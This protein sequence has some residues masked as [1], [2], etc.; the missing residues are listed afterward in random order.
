MDRLLA[1][2]NIALSNT[3]ALYFKI[4]SY[5]WNIEGSSFPQYHDFLNDAYQEIYESVDTYAEFIRALGAY[6]PISL[7]DIIKYK[8]I[9]DD[10]AKPKTAID[11]FNSLISSNNIMIETLNSNFKE[12]VD[13]NE[14]GFASF[15]ADRL[16]AHKKLA[17]K[18]NSIV[19]KG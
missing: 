16:I 15:I 13:N 12:A 10:S 11:M 19:K 18:L 2:S 4:H 3:F 9:S 17:W 8:S 7:P 5:H 6:A 14:Q 1:I